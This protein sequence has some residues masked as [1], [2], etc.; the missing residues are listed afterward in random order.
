MKWSIMYSMECFIETAVT[1]S[2]LKLS[3][4]MTNSVDPD[5]TPRPAASALG[6]H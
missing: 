3:N 5:V 4:V 6:L 1:G 2:I